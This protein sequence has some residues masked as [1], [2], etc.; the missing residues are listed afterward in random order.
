LV[1]KQILAITTSTTLS[2]IRITTSALAFN[3]MASLLKPGA[4]TLTVAQ[5]RIA[6]PFIL[7]ESEALTPAIVEQVQAAQA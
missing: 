7:W 6:L 4:T 2:R 5:F 1:H 3:A